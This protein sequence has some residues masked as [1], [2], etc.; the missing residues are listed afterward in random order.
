LDSQSIQHA[1][2]SNILRFGVL[3][4]ILG[5]VDSLHSLYRYLR[6]NGIT[7]DQIEW[8]RN[9]FTTID[10]LG[11]DYYSH[12]ER[13]W[14]NRGAAA[15]FE[16]AGF[17]NV[18]LEYAEHLNYEYPLMLTETNVRGRVSDR[19]SWLKY[20]V[21]E[22][23]NLQHELASHNNRF[24]GFCWYPYIDSTDWCHLVS[25]KH[26]CTDSHCSRMKHIDPQGIVWLDDEL[27]RNRS[28]LSLL[29]SK[30]ARGEMNA[31]D[32]PAYEFD[33]PVLDC[34]TGRMVQNYLP[35]F[36]HW[37]WKEVVPAFE[38]RMIAQAH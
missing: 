8:F 5:K 6:T 21:E 17:K 13:A 7:P 22:C 14:T 16:V 31:N 26:E 34:N 27:N 29:Y 32:I 38:T 12:S 9:H 28:E 23:S 24:L 11:L 2:Q 19:I 3:D 25:G 20:M 30:L 10:V 37:K 4:L 1:E 33:A 36:K 18:A 15:Q 35:H